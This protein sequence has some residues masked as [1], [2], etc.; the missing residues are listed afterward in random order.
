MK[1][2]IIS[3]KEYEVTE[4]TKKTAWVQTTNGE[5]QIFLTADGSWFWVYPRMGEAR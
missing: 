2:V 1:H 5:R 4:A 3:G